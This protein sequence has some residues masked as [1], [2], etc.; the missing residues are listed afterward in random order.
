[1]AGNRKTTRWNSR[2]K[3]VQVA[4]GEH[5]I[6]FREVWIIRRGRKERVIEIDAPE[7]LRFERVKR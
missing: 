6:T 5:V 1:M 4:C 7:C 2:K 3:P